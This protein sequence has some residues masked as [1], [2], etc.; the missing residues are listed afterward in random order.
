MGLFTSF[1]ISY[2]ERRTCTPPVCSNVYCFALDI[3]CHIILTPF[4]LFGLKILWNSRLDN[5][6]T[7]T[8]LPH[9]KTTLYFIHTAH[10]GPPHDS[11][12]TTAMIFLCMTEKMNV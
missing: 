9:F 7:R 2:K 3:H 4:L 5:N 11:E 6:I 12:G 1:P 10:L 8:A